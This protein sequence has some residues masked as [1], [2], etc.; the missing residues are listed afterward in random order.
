MISSRVNEPR[1]AEQL[2]M[3]LAIPLL[4]LFFG[5]IAGFVLINE[6]LIMWLALA[7]AL[8]DAGL[9]ALAIHLFQRDTILTRWK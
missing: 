1:A 2:S 4:A 9:L 8:I 7:L 3:L 5:R 6:A